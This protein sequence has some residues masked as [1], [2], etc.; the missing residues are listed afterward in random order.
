MSILSPAVWESETSKQLDVKIRTPQNS[1]L[2]SMTIIPKTW[3]E[4]FVET[5]CCVTFPA[6]T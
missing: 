2:P 6:S 3:G 1:M 5:F 4:W